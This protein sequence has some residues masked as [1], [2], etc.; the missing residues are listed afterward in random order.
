MP[1]DPINPGQ[2][3]IVPLEV[4]DVDED[5]AE[6]GGHALTGETLELRLYQDK[7]LEVTLATGTG[8][9]H[10]V[11][12]VTNPGIATATFAT[13]QTQGLDPEKKHELVLILKDAA[14]KP[15]VIA[16]PDVLDVE[17]PAL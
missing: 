16:G 15:K 3:L 10:D 13:T 7:N 17:W 14:S 1:L 11:D 12:Q 4:V 6:L 5:G 9:V 2:E 8:I